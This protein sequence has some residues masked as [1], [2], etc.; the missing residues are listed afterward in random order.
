MIGCDLS[1]MTKGTAVASLLLLTVACAGNSTTDATTAATPTSPSSLTSGTS[2]SSGNSSSTGGNGAPN[3]P[4]TVSAITASPN[5]GL[6]GITAIQLSAQTMDPLNRPLSFSWAFGD[7]QTSS[8]QTP[9]HIYTNASTFTVTLT[10]TAG[11][12]SATTQ[13]AV[14]VKSLTGNWQNDPFPDYLSLTQSGTSISGTE[15]ECCL[16]NGAPLNCTSGVGTVVLWSICGPLSGLVGT[17]SPQISIT[18]SGTGPIPSVCQTRFT[19]DPLD[20]DTLSGTSTECGGTGP[21]TPTS[22]HWTLKRQ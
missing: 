1:S 12:S 7:G 18:G 11:S 15:L 22:E 2:G 19:G 14:T 10:V 9:T 5:A 4:P 6:Q 3:T 8:A 16:S 21:F 17:T 20:V 13:T